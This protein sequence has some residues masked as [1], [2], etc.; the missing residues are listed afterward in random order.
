MKILVI[1]SKGFIGQHTLDH[2]RNLGIAAIGCDVVTDYEDANYV[3][4]D[5]TKFR[6]PFYF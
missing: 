3:Q 4:I 2:F 1:G 6:L 5:A